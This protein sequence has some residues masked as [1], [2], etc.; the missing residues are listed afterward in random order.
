MVMNRE[1]QDGS[2]ES[3]DAKQSPC[4]RGDKRRGTSSCVTRISNLSRRHRAHRVAQFSDH[5]INTVC[6]TNLEQVEY[7]GSGRKPPAS[8][9][10]IIGS[11]VLAECTKQYNVVNTDNCTRSAESLTRPFPRIVISMTHP[12]MVRRSDGERKYVQRTRS[13]RCMPPDHSLFYF[14]LVS[15]LYLQS[16]TVHAPSEYNMTSREDRSALASACLLA[17]ISLVQELI[18]GCS[19]S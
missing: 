14:H 5:R 7:Q 1:R 16:R 12:S 3:Q 11:V 2:S 8:I 9:D 18:P 4:A 10:E 13:P 15:A 19:T 6:A 17:L